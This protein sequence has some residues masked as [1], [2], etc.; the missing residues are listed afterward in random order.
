VG[1]CIVQRGLD[2]GG[3]NDRHASDGAGWVGGH[4]R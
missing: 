1:F 2:K 3:V 4:C